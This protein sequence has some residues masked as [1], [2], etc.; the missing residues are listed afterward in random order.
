MKIPTTL[1][2][3]AEQSR[4]SRFQLG[5]TQANVIEESSLPGHKL[6][7]FE[8]GRFVP[9]MP[10]L[11]GLRD[12]Y[13]Q[14]G[15]DFT[16]TVTVTTQVSDQIQTGQQQPPAHGGAMIRPVSRM[17]FYVS[18]RVE[19]EAVDQ[20]LGRMDGNDD[21]IAAIL[22]SPLK[23][24]FLSAYDEET[25]AKQRELFGAMAENYLLF[26]ILQ[27]RN[28]ISALPAGVEP[29]THADLLATFFATS[30]IAIVSGQPQAGK[31][32]AVEAAS[33]A[34]LEGGEE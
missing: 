14:K 27:G 25:E 19:P 21:R 29:A 2:I 31:E 6:K 8:T 3:T 34:E 4:A 23:G 5:L 16:E 9:D 7:N 17:C 11:E 13:T 15:I 20:I 26:R 33:E 28:I 22:Q 12:Y 10:F 1:P 18:D 32:K 30:P 24:G